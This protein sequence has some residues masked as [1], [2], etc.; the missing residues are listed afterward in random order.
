M[1][2]R[3]GDVALFLSRTVHAELERLIAK[4]P[5][6][7]ERIEY[8]HDGSTVVRTSDGAGWRI[9]VKWDKL[10]VSVVTETAE[11]RT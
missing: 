11:P 9:Y 6:R 1:S 7:V 2:L 10:S 3:V 5:D 8:L 4:D